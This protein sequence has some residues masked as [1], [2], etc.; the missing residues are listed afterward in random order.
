MMYEKI[1]PI[2]L[3]QTCTPAF[4]DL[5]DATTIC[6]AEGYTSPECVAALAEA[7]PEVELCACYLGEYITADDGGLDEP[8]VVV[9]N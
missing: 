9:K 3:L 2:S 6:D 7:L 4:G 1:R 8:C 5:Y